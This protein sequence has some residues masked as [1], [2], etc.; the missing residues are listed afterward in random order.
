MATLVN[1]GKSGKSGQRQRE[2]EVEELMV[3][4]RQRYPDR[5]VCQQD[6]ERQE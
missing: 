1:H 3:F 2:L 6:V 5:L 4:T